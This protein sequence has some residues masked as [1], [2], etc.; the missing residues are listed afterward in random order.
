MVTT[1]RKHN[2]HHHDR[3][4]TAFPHVATTL[5]KLQES[6]IKI[7]IVTTKMRHTV[8]M[9]LNVTDLDRYFETIIALDDVTHAKPHP[10]L[11]PHPA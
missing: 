4:V 6:D 9:G 5:E 10:E 3:F 1:Y 8:D 11:P 7:G 2:L